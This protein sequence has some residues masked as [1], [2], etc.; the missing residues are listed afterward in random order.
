MKTKCEHRHRGGLGWLFQGWSPPR[1]QERGEFGLDTGRS[2]VRGPCAGAWT[3]SAGVS[4]GFWRKWRGLLNRLSCA[5]VGDLD[6]SDWSPRCGQGLDTSF[7]SDRNSRYVHTKRIYF[8]GIIIY[9]MRLLFLIFLLAG[10]CRVS[11]AKSLFNAAIFA[12]EDCGGGL[13]RDY[14]QTMDYSLSEANKIYPDISLDY[15]MYISCDITSTVD[16]MSA[17]FSNKSLTAILEYRNYFICRTYNKFPNKIVP[18]ISSSC[19]NGN[20]F[21]STSPSDTSNANAL[22]SVL[23]YFEWGH[24]LILTENKEPM[25]G[26]CRETF[27]RLAEVGF[28]IVIKELDTNAIRDKKN[29]E[30]MLDGMNRGIKAFILCMGPAETAHFLLAAEQTMSSWNYA[31][32]LMQPVHVTEMAAIMDVCRS[33]YAAI[34]QTDNFNKTMKNVLLFGTA[35]P[36]I[37]LRDDVLKNAINVQQNMHDAVLLLYGAISKTITEGGNPLDGTALQMNMQGTNFT[38]TG[39]IVIQMDKNAQIVQDFVLFDYMCIPLLRVHSVNNSVELVQAVDF[40]RDIIGRD[41]CFLEDNCNTSGEY[42][43]MCKG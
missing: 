14:K 15:V 13:Y 41:E 31:I 4:A 5:G 1:T 18:M 35:Y 42:V 21:A 26:L 32:I 12:P 10:S 20:G 9:Y 30:T 38:S 19:S 16:K 8:S 28:S 43:S 39:K 7:R 22:M 24:L 6:A 11:L 29:M 2:S 17:S 25:I 34:S 40:W 36:G 33:S 37:N 3:L 23:K 27:I